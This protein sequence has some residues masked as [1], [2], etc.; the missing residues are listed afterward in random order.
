MEGIFLKLFNQSMYAGVL[1]LIVLIA[2]GIFRKAPKWVWPICWGIVGL[3]LIMPFT[4]RLPVS[5]MPDAEPLIYQM[6]PMVQV[7]FGNSAID[8]PVNYFLANT[9]VLQGY[10]SHKLSGIELLAGVWMVG[11]FFLLLYAFFSYGQL[12]KRVKEAVCQEENIFIC[13]EIATPFILGIFQPKIYLPSS[14]A[15]AN[16]EY[17]LRHEH[18]HLKRKDHFIKPVGYLLLA[19]GWFNPLMWVAYAFLCKDV[20]LACDEQVVQELSLEEKKNY[21]NALVDVSVMNRMVMV[22]PLSFGEVGIKTRVKAVLS[23]KKPA[24]WMI[25]LAACGCAFF[26][27]CFA[28]VKS[29]APEE[30]AFSEAK[31]QMTDTWCGN[32]AQVVYADRT[33]LVIAG[34]Y[35]EGSYGL[36]VYDKQKARVTESVEL[37]KLGQ[38]GDSQSENRITRENCVPVADSEGERIFLPVYGEKDMYVFDIKNNRITKEPY[39]LKKDE[40]H[41]A[42]SI[43]AMRDA[44]ALAMTVQDYDYG[45]LPQ[46]YDVWEDGEQ[47][48]VTF[49][50]EDTRISDLTYTDVDTGTGEQHKGGIF[51]AQ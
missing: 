14:L 32:E 19:I 15:E 16:R 45:M 10:G 26:A 28:T 22:C 43:K 5:L 12:R 30:I 50:S 3:R 27:L 25:G 40:I 1:V 9:M 42:G 2:R 36:F 4:L 24:A 41:E 17:V 13:D 49:L 33:R 20:E 6:H 38:E 29:A 18:A 47:Q 8:K 44:G 34:S 23:Y 48:Y 46:L 39:D 37:T 11:I 35:G 21:A 7:S 51:P 31:V